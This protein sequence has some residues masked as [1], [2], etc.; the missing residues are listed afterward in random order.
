MN[1]EALNSLINSGLLAVI[2]GIL[3]LI[4]V[5]LMI[6][7]FRF[8]GGELPK[9]ILFLEGSRILLTISGVFLSVH[10]AV[11]LVGASG[12]QVLVGVGYF[13][14]IWLIASLLM[15]LSQRIAYSR[16]SY[17]LFKEK[18]EPPVLRTRK[19]PNKSKV[20]FPIDM[21]KERSMGKASES[22]SRKPKKRRSKK[23]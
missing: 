13:A 18:G 23:A 3:S 14:L 21:M 12:R 5:P 19:K 4:A 22:S 17:R 9:P 6:Y 10:T 7:G 20:K 11:I 15:I 1:V 8:S 2:S 16:V